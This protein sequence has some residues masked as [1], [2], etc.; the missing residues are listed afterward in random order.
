MTHE[1]MPRR[2]LLKRIAG[3]GAGAAVISLPA[4]L[5]LPA[6]ATAAESDS[7]DNAAGSHP[8]SLN[9]WA[10][11]N[12]ANTGQGVWS[13]PVPGTGFS[14][15]TRLGMVETVLVHAIRRWNYEIETLRKGEV[16][17]WRPI[18]DLDPKGPESNQASGTAVTI[19]PGAYGKGIRGGLSKAQRHTVRSILDDCGGALRWGGNDSTPYEALFY[20]STPPGTTAARSITSPLGKAADRLRVLS[21]TPGKGAGTS[22]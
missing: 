6:P 18:A 16:I 5:L 22:A 21:Q 3:I 7:Q 13:C 12:R 9:G 1:A 8:T 17:G 11:A 20:I 14:V 2:E 19:R 15:D 4:G 10:L